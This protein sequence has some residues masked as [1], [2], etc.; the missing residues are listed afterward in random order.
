KITANLYECK[1]L[2]QKNMI[3]GNMET[4]DKDHRIWSKNLTLVYGE[5]EKINWDSLTP[6]KR[7]FLLQTRVNGLENLISQ[8]SEQKKVD[9]YKKLLQETNQQ[10]EENKQNIQQSIRDKLFVNK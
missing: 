3:T 6:Q 2:Q 5:D 10:I 4:I 8:S 7:E 1:P 9:E